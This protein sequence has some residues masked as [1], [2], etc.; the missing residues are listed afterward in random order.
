MSVASSLPG[1]WQWPA[2]VMAFALQHQLTAYLEPLLEAT[3]CL[4]PTASRL[5]VVLDEDAEVP[6]EKQIVFEVRVSVKDVPHFV[7]AV[8]LWNDELL[9]LCPPSLANNFG[10]TLQRIDP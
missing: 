6:D 5:Q 3:R 4:F 8:H 10:L 7:R 1:T 9:R 2:D